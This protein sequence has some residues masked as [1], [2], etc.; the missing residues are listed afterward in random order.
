MNKE[1]LK[2]KS[3]KRARGSLNN[4]TFVHIDDKK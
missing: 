4:N 3:C 2:K 1:T